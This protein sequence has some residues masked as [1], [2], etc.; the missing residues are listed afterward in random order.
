MMKKDDGN[1]DDKK[2][3][4]LRTDGPRHTSNT[5]NKGENIKDF[6]KRMKDKK[7]NNE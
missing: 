7:E 2:E 1:D 4:V 6:A 5:P 3:K